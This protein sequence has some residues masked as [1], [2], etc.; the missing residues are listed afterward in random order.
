MKEATALRSELRI[1]LPG[2][3]AILLAALSCASAEERSSAQEF[4]ERTGTLTVTDGSSYFTFNKSGVFSSGPVHES[5][6]SM[7]GCWQYAGNNRFVAFAT[8]GWMNGLSNGLESRR[9]TFSILPFS[10]NPRMS[11]VGGKTLHAAEAYLLI[12]EFVAIPTL[13]KVRVCQ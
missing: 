6:R 1:L 10:P 12:D 5:G 2:L 9:V 4:V 3:I 8:L 13:P 11:S 7:E